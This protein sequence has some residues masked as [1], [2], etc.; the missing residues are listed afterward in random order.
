M[1]S[2]PKFV[3]KR[4]PFHVDPPPKA[5][6]YPTEKKQL[7]QGQK[8][9]AISPSR[10]GSNKGYE[11]ERLSY[12]DELFLKGG[13]AFTSKVNQDKDETC[14]SKF[15]ESWP[16]TDRHLS[17]TEEDHPLN[18]V[19]FQRSGGSYADLKKTLQF[20]ERDT[21]L[22]MKNSHLLSQ[23]GNMRQD[24]SSTLQKYIDRFRTGQPMSREERKKEASSSQKDFWWLS[25]RSFTD[26]S[27]PKDDSPGAKRTRRFTPHSPINPYQVDKK[28]TSQ[29]F[30]A[31]VL[32]DTTKLLQEKADRLLDSA[33]SVG[34]SDPIVSTDGLGS[35]QSF[36]TTVSSVEEQPYRPSFARKWDKQ[37]KPSYQ[38]PKPQGRQ[39]S[40]PEDDVLYQWRLRRRM[41]QARDTAAK[42]PT[43][44]FGYKDKSQGQREIDQ[45]LEEFKQKLSG[46]S[47]QQNI[48]LGDNNSDGG[49]I[50]DTHVPVSHGSVQFTP[51]PQVRGQQQQFHDIPT[52]SRKNFEIASP[53]LPKT[54]DDKVEP[55]FHLTCDLIPCSH[56][57]YKQGHDS[58][59]DTVESRGTERNSKGDKSQLS[60]SELKGGNVRSNVK[61]KELISDE[62]TN[63]DRYKF[64]Q[65]ER[66][67]VEKENV[68]ND[69][70]CDKKHVIE[71][72]N[73][74]FENI[75]TQFRQTENIEMK[76]RR[77]EECKNQKRGDLKTQN[78]ENIPELKQSGNP[79]ISKPAMESAI[80]QVI[81]DR[82]F[83]IS[84]S[85]VLS[86]IDSEM[87][88]PPQQPK[89]TEVRGKK[90]PVTKATEDND[91]S[92]GEYPEDQLLH[93]LRQQRTQYEVQL[94]QIDQMLAKLEPEDR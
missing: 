20:P 70:E 14:S 2:E 64:L 49:F 33:S 27:T 28:S 39:P 71:E 22:S 15:D 11:E 74:S 62:E 57:G 51:A 77:S 40:R 37:D 29:S 85:T 56:Q 58:Q 50:N 43:V 19:I 93:M 94:R 53:L 8:K 54:G 9:T 82:L 67:D 52:S 81:K 66:P 73:D 59:S 4:D 1:I 44:K 60:G 30:G 47:V 32:D 10:S 63:S 18:D 12:N 75:N 84:N 31:H 72:E 3:A 91:E 35:S 38:I 68:D 80:G 46:K 83:N 76:K 25:D 41:E 26:S 78:R 34:S 21:S 92:D 89:F 65:A 69:E 36:S 48:S 13:N 23:N 86:S 90:L 17:I 79:T 45:K 87:S 42:T 55:H 5:H 88:S 61:D 24:S 6:Y 16:S 7:S